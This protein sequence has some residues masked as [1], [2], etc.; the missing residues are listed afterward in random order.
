MCM[1]DCSTVIHW[2][3]GGGGAEQSHLFCCSPMD[4]NQVLSNLSVH[5][6]E[7]KNCGQGQSLLTLSYTAVHAHVYTCMYMYMHINVLCVCL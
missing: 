5:E 6:S 7:G 2:G 1:M 3:V 4:V